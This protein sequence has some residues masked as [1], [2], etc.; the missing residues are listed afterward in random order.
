[1][2]HEI[3]VGGQRRL[4]RAAV[5]E[6]DVG[7]IGSRSE[8]ELV[9]QRAVVT[10]ER[11][12]DARPQVAVDDLFEGGDRGVPLGRVV[13]DQ[14][15]DPARSSPARRDRGVPRGSDEVE[16]HDV[17][18]RLIVLESDRH[19][20]LREE[21]RVAGPGR[22]VGDRVVELAAVRNERERELGISI[23]RCGGPYR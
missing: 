18:A 10:V 23:R 19:S 14:V 5:G 12:V 9:F 20:V 3:A 6:G 22:A 7:G 4:P 11:H 16:P 21:E 13:A 15:V 17:P 8:R 1:V 2:E